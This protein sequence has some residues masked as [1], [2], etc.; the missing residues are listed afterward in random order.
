MLTLALSFS[1]FATSTFEMMNRLIESE[2]KSF[3][4]ATLYANAVQGKSFLDEPAL[5]EFLTK[6]DVRD[7]V[8]DF[9][10]VSATTNRIFSDGYGGTYD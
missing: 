9:A 10:F 3:A 8:I 2:I 4:G 5:T 7:S 1:I 6:P